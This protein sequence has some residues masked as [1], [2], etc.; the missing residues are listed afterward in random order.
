MAISMEDMIQE[1]V[2][3]Q[4]AEASLMAAD[5]V[6]WISGNFCNPSLCLVISAGDP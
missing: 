6:A 3:M 4:G 5:E 1:G 2:E